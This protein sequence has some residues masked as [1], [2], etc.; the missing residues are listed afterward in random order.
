MREKIKAICVNKMDVDDLVLNQIYDVELHDVLNK[1]WIITIEDR[2]NKPYLFDFDYTI[3][4]PFNCFIPIA[5]H[6]NQ[7]IDSI[8]KD[9]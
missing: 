4:L 2:H 3:I 5:E 1:Q 8:L 7:R 9:D 6:R